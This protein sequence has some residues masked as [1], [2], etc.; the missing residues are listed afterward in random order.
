MNL[1]KKSFD[2]RL[3]LAISILVCLI[4]FALLTGS[5]LP[6]LFL[7]LTCLV[8]FLTISKEKIKKYF[9]NNF[10][11]IFLSFYIFLIIASLFSEDI[12][13]SLRSS[14]VYFRFFLFSFI[15]WYLLD[16]NKN[17]IKYFFYALL[18]A[19][20]Y[21]LIDGYYQ[22]FFGS[23]ITGIEIYGSRLSLP[24]HDKFILGGYIARLFPLL[25]GLYI[26]CFKQNYK[27]YAFLALLFILSDILVFVTGE[28]TAL[29]LMTLSTIAIICLISDFRFLRIF[30]FFIS[31]VLILIISFSNSKIKERNIDHTMEQV[32]LSENSQD[33]NIFS[34]EHDT[35]I[36]TGLNMFLEKPLFGQGPNMFRKLCDR[37]KYSNDENSCSTHPHNNQIQLLAETG[38][39]GLSYSFIFFIFIITDIMRYLFFYYFR[40][41]K[42]ISNTQI[43]IY[44]SIFLTL[45]PFFPTLNFFTNWINVV[46]YLP[47]GF[48]LYFR[49]TKT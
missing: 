17:L 39:I 3:I 32:G 21:A 19:Y 47:L 37:E 16:L 44:I 42:I 41:E 7:S 12:F 1:L 13:H 25:V 14:I 8:F 22:Y 49:Y 33:I 34:P 5:F 29:G 9:N 10:F 40:N 23:T 26:Y 45:W 30:T 11:Y 20:S 36:R 15:V 18:I 28:R 38:V 6:D 31:I 35:L 48:F 46:Y 2:Q 43:C 4:P 24:L 27:N